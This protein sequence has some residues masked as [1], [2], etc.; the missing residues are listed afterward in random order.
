LSRIVTAA[1]SLLAMLAAP[2]T[3]ASND[4]VV[5]GVVAGTAA[6]TAARTAPTSPAIPA[7]TPGWMTEDWVDPRTGFTNRLAYGCGHIAELSFTTTASQNYLLLHLYNEGRVR[8][9]IR[10]EDVTV[11]FPSGR[12]RRLVP[13]LGTGH[14]AIDPGWWASAS[15]R[16]PDKEDFDGQDSMTL[17][18]PVDAGGACTLEVDVS[19]H[20]GMPRD[21][22]TST[23]YQRM[24]MYLAGG[25]HLGSSGGPSRAAGSAR[26]S[27]APASWIGRLEY[28][29]LQ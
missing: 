4:A 22:R 9:T 17:G 21:P 14:L 18:V 11:R 15:F 29:E 23:R 7:V 5:A 19:R 3:A 10:S 25:P 1:A 26:P 20:P 28:R 2:S 13:A 12:E 6:G 8:S 24:E 27:K 16:F